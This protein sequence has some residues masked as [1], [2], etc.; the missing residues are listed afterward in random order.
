MA[1]FQRLCLLLLNLEVYHKIAFEI[2]AVPA[3]AV[4][5]AMFTITFVAD[6]L[7]E[8]NDG[9]VFLFQSS[10]RIKKIKL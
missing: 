2:L 9:L 6:A 4:L 10:I 8:I 7:I 3:G 1:N 5:T